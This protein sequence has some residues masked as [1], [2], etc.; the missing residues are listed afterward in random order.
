MRRMNVYSLVKVSAVFFEQK[1]IG[2]N[3]I[4]IKRGRKNYS[5]LTLTIHR[6]ELLAVERA[7]I[8][9]ELLSQ[10]AWMQRLYR[11]LH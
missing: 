11:W 6:R 7:S 5:C 3:F 8:L 4:K 1:L 2:Y 10:I 9:E